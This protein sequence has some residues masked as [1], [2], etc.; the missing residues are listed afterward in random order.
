MQPNVRVVGGA[1][2]DFFDHTLPLTERG[3][4]EAMTTAGLEVVERRA[5]FLPYT[6]K[7]AY[8]SSPLLV[9]AYLALPFVHRFLGAQM[10]VVGR[11][12]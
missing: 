5:R 2:W 12:Q 7:G 11:K 6:T 3:M 10:L 4:A 8:P 1:F 9:R